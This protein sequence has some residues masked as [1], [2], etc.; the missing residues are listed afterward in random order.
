MAHPHH[1]CEPLLAG[2]ITTRMD[3]EGHE[4]HPHRRH[5]QLLLGWKRGAMGTARGQDTRTTT[6]TMTMDDDHSDDH[7]DN[8]N[9]KNDGHQRLPDWN[10]TTTKTTTVGPRWDDED[11]DN[12]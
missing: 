6:T 9:D 4:Q 1:R 8:D 2:W 10:Q 3:N 12:A 5:K 11:H 7:N